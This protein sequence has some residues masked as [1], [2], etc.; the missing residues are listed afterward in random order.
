[1]AGRKP[2]D[3]A[4][5]EDGRPL[6]G[7]RKLKS[8]SGECARRVGGI[9]DVAYGLTSMVG[10]QR[11][12]SDESIHVNGVEVSIMGHERPRWRFRVST[13]MLLVITVALVLTLVNDQDDHDR[14]SPRPRERIGP[15][16]GG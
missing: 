16:L 9:Q 6:K 7:V 1:M 8:A 4:S 14:R 3:T 10:C 12:N 13:L 11:W 2:L 5:Y 15:M